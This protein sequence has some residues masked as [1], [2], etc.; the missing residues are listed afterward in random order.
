LLS[1]T[2]GGTYL[3][4]DGSSG[5]SI[6]VNRSGSYWLEV[7]NGGCESRDTVNVFIGRTPRINLPSDTS[8]CKGGFLFLSATWPASSYSW[9]TGS[10]DSVIM[11]AQAGTYRVTVSNPCGT[12]TDEVNV[13]VQDNICNLFIPTAFTP[14]GDGFNEFFEITGKEITPVN[15]LIFNRWGEKVF[16]SSDGNFA[17]DGKANG[18]LCQ[19]GAYAWRFSY[20][21]N[22]GSFSRLNTFDG[23][24]QLIW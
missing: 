1:S 15:L 8:L 16:Q 20:R 24:V 2:A 13:F 4:S 14:N 3:W 5:N 17:W 23:T 11:A 7:S 21:L 19:P 9:S 22:L 6:T 18:E 10:R 12:A